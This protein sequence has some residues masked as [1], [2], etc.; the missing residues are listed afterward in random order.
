MPGS[1]P[2]AQ[3]PDN[4][5]AQAE[6]V[7]PDVLAKAEAVLANPEARVGD[8][9]EEGMAMIRSWIADVRARRAVATS[10][11]ADSDSH[12]SQAEPKVNTTELSPEAQTISTLKAN[13]EAK[14]GKLQTRIKWAEVEAKLRKSP[15]K[16]AVL[17]K[18]IDRGGEPT[19]TAKVGGNFRFDELSAESP[20]G[21]RDVNFDQAE[22]VASDLGAE[23]TEPTVYNTFKSKGIILDIDTYSWLRTS[24]EVR[25][26]R[27]A[28][29][30]GRGLSFKGGARSHRQDGGL[31]CS[32][33][34]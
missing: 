9:G 15:E 24:A 28:F 11:E 25:K 22:K 21:N 3:V 13:F 7:Q 14:E 4:D 33:E 17:Q 6:P 16:L 30:G 18:L 8:L 32:L 1:E 34:V 27:R 12:S 31:R 23:L 10:I 5:D 19:V 2:Q 26:T 20:I 29:Y